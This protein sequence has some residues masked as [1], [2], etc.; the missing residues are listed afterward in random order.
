MSY[1]QASL[2]Q[3]VDWCYILKATCVWDFV[4]LISYHAYRRLGIVPTVRKVWA[5]SHALAVLGPC[6]VPHL[7][8]TLCIFQDFEIQCI[9]SLP[10]WSGRG[11]YFNL[12]WSS[13]LLC[14]SW[15]GWQIFAREDGNWRPI[16]EH[17][18]CMEFFDAGL[19]M[20]YLFHLKLMGKN[21]PQES[22][23]Q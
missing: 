21:G 2:Y 22:G 11:R 13:Y 19:K 15:T 8:R 7:E 18:V 23:A 12:K 17:S 9:I 20:L 6:W 1:S 16:R 3:Y 14:D 4:S 5:P 10:M